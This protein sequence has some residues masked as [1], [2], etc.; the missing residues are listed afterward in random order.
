MKRQDK[1][2]DFSACTQRAEK[3][4]DPSKNKMVILK[5]PTYDFSLWAKSCT[6]Q[7]C[8]KKFKWE[9]FHNDFPTFT[10]NCKVNFNKIEKFQ[11]IPS[12]T[13][14]LNIHPLSSPK[15]PPCKISLEIPSKSQQIPKKSLHIPNRYYLRIFRYLKFGYSIV[16]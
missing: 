5:I 13:V 9:F 6:S 8:L 11:S 15:F 16:F 4:K 12:W 7:L 14:F 10:T 2:I 1:H 3:N